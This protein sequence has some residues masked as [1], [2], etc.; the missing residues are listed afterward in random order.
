MLEAVDLK[1]YFHVVSGLFTRSRA[2]VKA[3]DGVSLSV[4]RGETLGL[5]GESGCGKSTLGRVIARL[6]TPTDG[7]IIF[8]GM[9]VTD[10]EGNELRN[11]RKRVQ[12]IFQDPYSSLNPRMSAGAIVGEALGIHNLA[13][14]KERKRR[15]TE[16]LTTVGLTE[17]QA[18]RY[19]HEFSGG[20]RQRIGIA[21]A[22]SVNP[23]LIIADEPVSAL[24][25]SIQAQILNLLKRLQR[26]FGL[27]Y[28]FISHD[29]GVVG[30]VSDRIAVMYLG[31][32]VEL[33][34]KSQILQSPRHPYTRALLSA[35]P[36]PDPGSKK[37]RIP[38]P[39]DIPSPFAPPPGCAFHPRCPYRMDIC[40]TRTPELTQC[41]D[42]HFAACH[43]SGSDLPEVQVE[44]LR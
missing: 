2:T 21:R 8:D 44:R 40:S 12:L 24:D 33:G 15:V 22:L 31:K 26:E 27:T 35:V 7:R 28:I 13:T 18:D 36:V 16:L 25:V 32:I 43:L 14:G 34:E 19:P 3:V 23:D 10:I 37:T 30:H 5:V 20:Q 6:D 1:K 4:I 38:L 17:E 9:N 29:L 11:F 42:G 41:E 39:G